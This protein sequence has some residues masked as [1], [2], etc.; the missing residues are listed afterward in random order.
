MTS[1]ETKINLMT[2]AKKVT[3]IKKVSKQINR[4]NPTPKNVSPVK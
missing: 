2:K 4:L 1:K 3:K